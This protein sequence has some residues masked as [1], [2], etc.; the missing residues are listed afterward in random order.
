MKVA[1][2]T[3][4][5]EEG[6]D[7]VLDYISSLNNQTYNDFDILLLNDNLSNEQ[8]SYIYDNLIIKP[9]IFKNMNGLKPHQLRVELIRKAKV[10]NYDLLILG[11][12]DDVFSED[13]ISSMVAEFD[14]EFCFFYNELY[15][16]GSTKKFFSKIPD[17]T[18]DIG[19]ILESNYIGLS[20][21]ALNLNYITKHIV[22]ELNGCTNSVFDWYMYSLLLHLGLKGKK[23]TGGKTF[24]RIHE[25]NIA[26]KSNDSY[27]DIT[28]ELE[29]KIRHYLALKN[30]NIIYSEKLKDYIKL[31]RDIENKK[32]NIMDYIDHGNDYW[33]GKL[34]LNKMECFK[35]D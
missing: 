15:Y 21:S 18:Q 24:Y 1:F 27:E 35:N 12:F 30:K 9:K 23:I 33:W 34:N 14:N 29:I 3:V 4:I 17:I 5:Y 20:N 28:K 31:K 19:C 22:N 2:G 7:Y 10:E 26:G 6:F 32:L 11:D 13:R 8:E 25:L 16:M